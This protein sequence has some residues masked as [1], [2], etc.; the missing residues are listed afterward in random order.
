MRN[1]L[2]L[3]VF[4]L[5]A[6]ITFPAGALNSASYYFNLSNELVDLPYPGNTLYGEVHLDLPMNNHLEVNV[7]PFSWPGENNSSGDFVNSPL[8]ASTN[9]G[10]QRFAMDSTLVT[11]EEDY[12]TFLTLYDIEIPVSWNMQFNG[13]ISE[14]GRFEFIYSGTGNTRQDPLLISISPKDGADLTGYEFDSVLAFVE[15]NASGYHFAA[16]IAGFTTDESYWRNGH[17]NVESGYFAIV[18][19]EPAVIT[20]GVIGILALLK[21][22]TK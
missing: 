8:V 21:K 5:V 7:N 19:P 17:T 12:D 2:G 20:L 6:A 1:V 18:V 15:P 14:F 11:T 9:F 16:H 3:F 22:R 13:Q 10:I 4:L